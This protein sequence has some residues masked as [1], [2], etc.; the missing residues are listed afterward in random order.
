[1]MKSKPIKQFRIFRIEIRR[2]RR[3]YDACL[4]SFGKT[5]GFL[6]EQLLGRSINQS[7]PIFL[8]GSSGRRLAYSPIEL[9]RAMKVSYPKMLREALLIRVVSQLENYFVDLVREV[10]RRD[11]RPFKTSQSDLQ[12]SRN[13]LLSFKDMGEIVDYVVSRECRSLNGKSFSDIK[14]YYRKRL[15]IDFA[16]SNVLPRDIDEIYARRHLLV[17]AGGIVDRTYCRTH[18][19]SMSP[20]DRIDI[21]EDYFLGAIEKLEVL[22]HYCSEEVLQKY[23]IDNDLIKSSNPIFAIGSHRVRKIVDSHE[24]GGAIIIS[25]IRGKFASPE[26]P[27]DHFSDISEFGYGES[28]VRVS[29]VVVGTIRHSDVEISWLVCGEKLLAGSYIGYVMYLLRTGVIVEIAKEKVPLERY[30]FV[31]GLGPSPGGAS[32]RKLPR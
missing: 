5:R 22:A 19:Q 9:F 8:P 29:E 32:P 28:R 14:D 24:G 27:D 15:D 20:G 7:S 17:H 2:I 31:L 13:H 30:P 25:A 3:L 23:P 12:F 26:M 10:S 18:A 16:N 21:D 1:M 4:Y 6:E 11:L